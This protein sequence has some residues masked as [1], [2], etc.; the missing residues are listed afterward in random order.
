MRSDER[1]VLATELVDSHVTAS[2]EHIPLSLS[3]EFLAARQRRLAVRLRSS[4][5]RRLA[6]C[7]TVSDF[8]FASQRAEVGIPRVV[9]RSERFFRKLRLSDANGLLSEPEAPSYAFPDG[10]W[11]P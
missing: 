10:G 2:A 8:A 5:F 1:L 6:V 11:L 9:R 3:I 4:P 7:P